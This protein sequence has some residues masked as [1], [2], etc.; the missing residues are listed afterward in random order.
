MRDLRNLPPPLPNGV[1]NLDQFSM[2]IF[3]ETHGEKVLILI[4][5]YSAA[6][7]YE[8][9]LQNSLKDYRVPF[10]KGNLVQSDDPEPPFRETKELKPI[11]PLGCYHAV[12]FD[13]SSR[14]YKSLAGAWDY[15]LQKC[16][17]WGIE[18]VS[19]FVIDDFLGG[20]NSTI[21]PAYQKTF[22]YRG[23]LMTLRD[24]FRDIYNRLENDDRKLT[25]YI[26]RFVSPI[27]LESGF[28]EKLEDIE[29]R[30]PHPTPRYQEILGK[31]IIDVARELYA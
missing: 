17:E 7:Y 31:G 19:A 21:N 3:Q 24:W 10:V 8:H 22:K 27:H 13:N 6:L 18:D 25:Q 30:K 26:S 20:T 1:K 4:L 28:I 16:P 5:G 14:T 23:P 12:I 2:E 9:Y 11:D 15:V 29:D